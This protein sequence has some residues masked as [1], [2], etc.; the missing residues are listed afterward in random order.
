VEGEVGIENKNSLTLNG[1]LKR[2][3]Q[4]LTEVIRRKRPDVFQ[5]LSENSLLESDFGIFPL[6]MSPRGGCGI[7]ND[8]NDFLS[9][10]VGVSSPTKAG[11]IYFFSTFFIF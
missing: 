6:F 7:H 4:K 2:M 11:L 1:L 8:P 10:V 9:V 3:G 5:V